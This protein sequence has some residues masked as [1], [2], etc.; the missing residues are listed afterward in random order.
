MTSNIIGR[1]VLDNH[2]CRVNFKI[3][4]GSLKYYFITLE[5]QHFSMSHG[6]V[7]LIVQ[8]QDSKVWLMRPL[9][10]TSHVHLVKAIISGQL[11][12]KFVH[13]P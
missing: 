12:V 3:S 7:M 4:M 10:P 11:N 13:L 8:K 6:Y 9:K 5:V 2:M 1:C